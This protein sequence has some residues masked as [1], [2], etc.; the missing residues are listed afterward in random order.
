MPLVDI[1]V[2]EG[3]LDDAQK[4][5]MFEKLTD[6]MVEV[7]GETMRQV[8]WVR[9]KEVRSG[10]RGIGTTCSEPRTSRRWPRN[11]RR[12][13]PGRPAGRP[14]AP[15]S[16]ISRW[17]RHGQERS[18]APSA[19]ARRDCF[20]ETTGACPARRPRHSRGA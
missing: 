11:E 19:T 20:C 16:N 2:I 17:N 4:A 1:E 9:V 7:G 8:I 5:K 6:A 13:R 15:V 14:G 18:R 12:C 10:H 3:V